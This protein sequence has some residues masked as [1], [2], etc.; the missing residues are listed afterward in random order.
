MKRE[1]SYI[2]Y[3]LG[4][5][6][7]L[8]LILAMTEFLESGK[9]KEKQDQGQTESELDLPSEEKEET[10][11]KGQIT[12]DNIRVLLMTTGY[13][14]VYHSM[15]SLAADNGLRLIMGERTEEWSGGV[16]T[17]N[18][19]D[20]R[21]AGGMLRVEPLNPEEEIRVESLERGCGIPSYDGA[22][23]IWSGEEGMTIINEL[24]L[25]DYLCKVVP[26][27]MPS[28]YEEEALKA[29]AVCA[30]S[31]AARQMTGMAY[32]KY[33]A[34]VNDST[35]FQVYNNSYTAETASN[36]VKETAGQV[37]WHQNEIAVTYYYSTSC[38]TTT[39]ME[40]WGTAPDEGNAY[41][42]SVEVEE[43]GIDYEKELPWYRWCAEIPDQLMESLLEAYAGKD[44]GTLQSMEVTRRGPGGIALE[45][46]VTGSE[47]SVRI[48][49]ENKIRTAFGGSGYQIRKN[50]GT[51][52]DSRTLLPSA[53]FTIEKRGDVY[54]VDG[55]GFGHGIGMSQNGAN[56]MAKAGKTYK[57][58]LGLFYPGTVVQ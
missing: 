6:L 49:T 44:L 55:G 41:L 37:V 8:F 25:E 57:E 14:D 33:H 51:V 20:E 2:V 21:F 38:G 30:R 53:F 11:G 36:A 9:K 22:L 45:L 48:E 46:T 32:P 17:L 39:T 47:D 34:N 50:D 56:E 58:I 40:A 4:I 31:Y 29:Q 24:P 15:V 43:H 52:T 27:E 13:S 5:M 54:I 7:F 35:D 1:N 18:P 23:E 12:N 26:S 10:G 3:I 42:Q 16:L 19:D 28:S